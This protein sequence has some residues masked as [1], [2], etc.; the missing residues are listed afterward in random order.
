MTALAELIGKL[1]NKKKAAH[2]SKFGHY[3]DTVRDLASGAEIDSDEVAAVL[4][5]N[6]RDETSLE[7]DVRLQEQRYSW[8]A[9]MRANQQ[10]VQDRLAAENELQ[11]AQQKLQAAFD[12]L[13]PA[14]NDAHNKLA[15]ANHRFLITQG[16]DSL[17]AGNLLD[18][19]LLEREASIIARLQDIVAE[20][21]PLVKDR[22]FKMDSLQNAEFRLAQMQA[23]KP[24][25]WL[26]F[27]TIN[28]NF[29]KNQSIDPEKQNVDD[30]QN[31]LRQLDAA[32]N[33]RQTEQ[34]RLQRELDAIHQQKLL[35]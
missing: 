3:L 6:G 7:K 5:A 32:I 23:R 30:L 15:D 18:S 10:A 25:D 26:G 35:P 8:A 29:W 14:V 22:G 9:T 11:T 21:R 24:G 4:D 2:R 34:A 20:L 31:Q 28:P 12:K 17:L 13:Q 1:R 19:E 27:G 33:P 16:A